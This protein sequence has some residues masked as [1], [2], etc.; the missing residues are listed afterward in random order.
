MLKLREP[1]MQRIARVLV[2]RIEKA[3]LGRVSGA[4]ANLEARI[5]TAFRKN[6]RAEEEIE[7]EAARFA[8]SHGRELV[9]M[10]RYKVLQLVKERIA[11]Q[12]GFTL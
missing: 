1:E 9:G 5:V 11:K 7:A 2:E 3:G 8:E 4:R 10:D 12:K 6:I